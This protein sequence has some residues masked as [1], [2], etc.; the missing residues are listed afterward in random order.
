MYIHVP[1]D[2]FDWDAGNWPKCGKHGVERREIE[3]VFGSDPAVFP[4]PVHSAVETRYLAI[5]Q[6][7]AGRWVFV[8][9]TLRFREGRTLVRPISARFMHAKEIRH[10]QQQ[11]RQR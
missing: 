5:G 6:T 11:A 10:F 9:F 7:V 1:I 3:Q 8:A 2:G 4:D